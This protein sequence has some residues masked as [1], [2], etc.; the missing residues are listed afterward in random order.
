MYANEL[1][2]F[3]GSQSCFLKSV[4]VEGNGQAQ[5]S[6]DNIQAFFALLLD[7]KKYRMLPRTAFAQC[8]C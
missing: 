2:N 8:I 4:V 6:G 1:G 3:P 5:L 7:L